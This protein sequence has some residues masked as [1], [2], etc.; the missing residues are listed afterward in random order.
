M[1]NKIQV[2]VIYHK[3]CMDGLAAAFIAKEALGDIFTL[4]LNYGEEET[5]YEKMEELGILISQVDI[6]FVDFSFKRNLMIE[7]CSKVK[8]VVVIDHH[9]TAEENLKGLDKEIENIK[10]V[11]DMNKSGATLA[12]EYFDSDLKKELF[13]Y[14][15]DRDLWK[16]ELSLSKEISE[17]L[18]LYI[19]PNNLESFKSVYENFYLSKYSFVGL[20]LTQKLEQQVASKLK[21]VRDIKILDIN[22]KIINVSEN[23]S[24]LGNA[25][26]S[27]YNTPAMLY[28]ITEETRVFCSFRSLDTLADVS[29]VAKSFGG[30]GHRNACGCSFELNEFV[31]LL[32]GSIIDY[33]EAKR[34]V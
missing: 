11:F 7:L 28:F 14:V 15:E 17:A 1:E 27:E 2:L 6:Y 24:E 19:K 12:Y 26:C 4:P 33:A 31:E 25:I 34:L 23:I 8:R 21:K 9:K 3:N 16:W 20:A 29:V 30:G 10:I 13:T 18:K 5:V 22:F 32:N